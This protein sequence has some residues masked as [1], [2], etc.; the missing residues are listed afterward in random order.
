M[1]DTVEE[2]KREIADLRLMLQAAVEHGDVVERILH[3]EI[4]ERKIAQS[5]LQSILSAVR[6][7]KADIEIMLETMVEHGETVIEY[8]LQESQEALFQRIAEATPI[9]MLVCN[10]SDRRVTYANTKAVHLLGKDILHQS[11]QNCII[12]DNDWQRL[13]AELS[14]VG[15]VEAYELQMYQGDG[16]PFWAV[17]SIHQLSLK[18][19]TVLLY[20]LFDI[21]ERKRTEARLQNSE[22]I[23]REQAEILEIAVEA[24]TLELQAA[25][26]KYRRIFEN[27]L[28]G[29]YQSTADS[30]GKFL[31]VN[32]ALA[33]I[34]KY[35]SPAQLIASISNI[36]TQIY[37]DSD[38]RREFINLICTNE[39]ITNFESEVYCRDG[40]KIWIAENAKAVRDEK[41]NI[42]FFEGSVQDI[43]AKRQAEAAL[44]QEQAKSERLLLNILPKTVAER[45]KSEQNSM[46]ADSY[47]DVS[48]LFADIVEF[49]TVASR[50]SP[51]ELVGL[52][53]R[54]F[55]AFDVLAEKYHLEKIKTIGDEY[56]V[57]GGLP[58][59]N[60]HH[61]QAIANMALDMQQM[62]KQF[63]TKHHPIM[64]LRIGI[65]TGSVIAGVIGQ[66]K[67]S[68]DLW[69]DAV[70]LA[71]R[72]ETQGEPGKIQVSEMTYL[73]LQDQFHFKRRG[74][75]PVKGKGEMPTYWLEGRK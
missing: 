33:R 75:I 64:N 70:N 52:L 34:Y 71:S 50:I 7:S 6:R 74:V 48:I 45:L 60:P 4:S 22:A 12:I 16:S 35:D 23:L 19:E 9:A 58:D 17:A 28:E 41:G 59:P 73:R 13:E 47:S 27:A 5:N 54:I 40:T 18:G 61:A 65:N 55:S 32:P 49:T 30:P 36:D 38:R 37:V 25:E 1:S 66:S 31:A 68:F 24:R 2:L 11:I 63:R 69:G 44:R 21:T 43:T 15:K 3:N 53:N 20:T 67:F 26:E 62:I 72:M 29:I 51:K 46:I 39:Q 14:A 10:D 8:E 56:M 42:L 57:V